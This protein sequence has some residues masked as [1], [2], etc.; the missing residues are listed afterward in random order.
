[1]SAERRGPSPEFL[2][3]VLVVIAAFLAAFFDSWRVARPLDD[4]AY[5]PREAIITPEIELLQEYLRFDT[6]N[7]PGREAEAAEW[8]A[9]LIRDAGVDVELIE[10]AP[11]RT[12]LVARL[13]GRM[14]GDGLLLTHHI[15]V[16][17]VD[18]AAWSEPPF[19]G[20][21][22]MNQLFGR[23]ALDMKSIGICHLVAFLDLARSGES[24]ERDIV[25]LAVADEEQGGELGMGWIVRHRPDILEGVRYALNEGGVAESLRDDVTYFGVEVGT[26]QMVHLRIRAS[27]RRL[28]E[29]VR[30]ALLPLQSPEDVDRILPEVPPTL[31][32]LS[33]HRVGGREL[34]AD[35]RKAVAEGDFWKLHQSY[36]LLMQNVARLGGLE[37]DEESLFF[38][39]YLQNL[40]DEDPYGQIARVRSIV[41]PLGARLVVEKVQGPSP[42]SNWSTP[43]FR[44]IEDN[45][46]RVYGDVP[47]GPQI[48]QYTSND[49]RFLRP[50][51]IDAYGF[52]PFP[53][54]LYQTY[55][56][57]GVDERVRLDWFMNGVDLT[58]QLVRG[59]ATGATQNGNTG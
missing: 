17:E 15:D 21:V 34:L 7:P 19:A 12:N 32:A 56:I 46:Q 1:M 3:V 23:G 37:A 20:N 26:K 58:R 53:V 4:S 22:R 39:V 18:E 57:H 59:W 14:D 43:F 29:R 42:I 44:E 8:L 48:Q 5:V 11:G 31:A 36:R 47:V 40:P 51:G 54:N 6:S 27:E 45:V 35:V 2:G 52:W 55:G 24:L 28:L 49:S 33:A 13:E 25:F 41:E 9:G 30:T 38:D 16:A 50:L 10:T